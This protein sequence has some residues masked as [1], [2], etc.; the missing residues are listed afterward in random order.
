MLLSEIASRIVFEAVV[1]PTVAS[2]IARIVNRSQQR[3]KCTAYFTMLIRSPKSFR[4]DIARMGEIEGCWKRDYV[5]ALF[6]VD[7]VTPIGVSDN[8]KPVRVDSRTVSRIVKALA[9]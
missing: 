4:D 7:S 1:G 3:R 2:I 8:S 5:K 9:P 6:T